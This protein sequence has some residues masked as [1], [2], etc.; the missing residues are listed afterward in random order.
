MLRIRTAADD[1]DAGGDRLR[2]TCRR[3]RG[4]SAC[5]AFGNRREPRLHVRSGRRQQTQLPRDRHR[6]RST[7][8]RGDQLVVDGEHVAPLHRRPWRRCARNPGSVPAR[9]TSRAR[10][11]GSRSGPGRWSVD[12]LER[13]VRKR[14]EQHREVRADPVGR[15]QVPLAD[16][17]VDASRAPSTRRRRRDRCSPSALK[18][19]FA[20]SEVDIGDASL[21]ARLTCALTMANRARGPRREV[22]RGERVLPG[23]WRLRLPLPWPGVPHCNAWAIAAGRESCSSTPG[24]TSRARWRDLERALEQV[25]P[26]ARA[27]AAWSCAR[28]PTPTTGARRRP[29]RDRAGCEVWMHPNH[30]PCDRVARGPRGRARP[31]TRGRSP[32]RR[33]RAGAARVRR[34]REGLPH[35]A[36]PR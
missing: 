36:S 24:C 22:G 18:Y 2:S 35:P 21:R 6:C 1:P 31:A 29:I 16:D 10:A 5:R 34:A 28:T 15:D 17:P 9:R 4:A 26:G 20:I 19:R 23:L 25:E 13:E 27:G 7:R 8:L 14:L 3:R 32:E 30:E 11:T 12:D 33:V